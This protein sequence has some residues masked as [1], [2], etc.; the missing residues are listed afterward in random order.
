MASVP[1]AIT[2]MLTTSTSILLFQAGWLLQGPKRMT[3]LKLCIKGKEAKK[4]RGQEKWSSRNEGK[5]QE[6]TKAGKCF[7]KKQIDVTTKSNEEFFRGAW[8]CKKHYKGRCWD[9]YG[10]LRKGWVLDN[11]IVSVIQFLSMMMK[12]WL[13]MYIGK[14]LLS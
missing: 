12:L 3:I 14:Y 2:N 1:P 5:E 9:K 6:E 13:C 10:N 11:V 4:Q 7:K 8:I